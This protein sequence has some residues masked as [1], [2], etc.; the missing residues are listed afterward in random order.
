M[1]KGT[2]QTGF[3]LLVS[4]IPLNVAAVQAERCSLFL[5]DRKQQEMVAKVSALLGT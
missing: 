1:T 5:V 4:I 3:K 2:V